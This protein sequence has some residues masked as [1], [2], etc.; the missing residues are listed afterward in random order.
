MRTINAKYH[1]ESGEWQQTDLHMAHKG[2]LMLAQASHTLLLDFP[3]VH[4]SRL[5]YSKKII[6]IKRQERILVLFSLAGP[7]SQPFSTSSTWEA[8]LYGLHQWILMPLL[9]RIGRIWERGSEL[10]CYQEL[11]VPIRWRTQFLFGDLLHTTLSPASLI[12]VSL[13]FQFWESV[14]V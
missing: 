14:R 3:G 1:T 8:D 7:P 6:R 13:V 9:W 2:F 4:K 5:N 12:T 11:P 10:M